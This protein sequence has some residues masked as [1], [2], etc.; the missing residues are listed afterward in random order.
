MRRDDTGQTVRMKSRDQRTVRSTNASRH[1]AR[2]RVAYASGRT[3]RSL[4]RR[5]T[6]YTVRQDD[7]AEY[8]GQASRPSLQRRP[9]TNTGDHGWPVNQERAGVWDSLGEVKTA[10]CPLHAKSQISQYAGSVH[11]LVLHT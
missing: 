1:V 9:A 3:W 10:L 4:L 7:T 6:A 2:T 11:N 5:T 8:I